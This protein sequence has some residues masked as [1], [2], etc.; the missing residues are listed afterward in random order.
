MLGVFLTFVG[1]LSA[2]LVVVYKV[3]WNID[4]IPEGHCSLAHPHIFPGAVHL[5]GAP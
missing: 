1:L 4:D 3:A 2:K 5:N